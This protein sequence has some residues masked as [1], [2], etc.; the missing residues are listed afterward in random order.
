MLTFTHTIDLRPIHGLYIAY[1]GFMY[2]TP[3]KLKKLNVMGTDVPIIIDDA[4]CASQGAMGLHVGGK[5]VLLS[6]YNSVTDYVDTLSHEVF[7][8]LN[9]ILGTQLDQN[10]EE[11]LANTM[12]QTNVRLINQFLK[13]G[14]FIEKEK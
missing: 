9:Y 1:G 3:K 13:H 7:H 12:G 4:F 14:V 6:Q 11:I 5:I 8:A 2:K 10:L